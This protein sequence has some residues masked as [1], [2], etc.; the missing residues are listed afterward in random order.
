MAPDGHLTPIAIYSKKIEIDPNEI[1]YKRAKINGSLFYTDA[2]FTEAI[3]LLAG[4]KSNLS[5]IVTH[6][7]PLSQLPEAFKTQADSSIS[8]KVMVEAKG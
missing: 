7:F 6:T 4:G 3:E 8:V 1:V 5:A 2:D